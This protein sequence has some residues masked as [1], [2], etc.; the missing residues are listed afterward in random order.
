MLCSSFDVSRVVRNEGLTTAP[1]KYFRVPNFFHEVDGI[2]SSDGCMG[3]TSYPI[4]PI[5]C[6]SYDVSKIISGLT[7]TSTECFHGHTKF[8]H[9]LASVVGT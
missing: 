2:Y 1:I 7:T 3:P 5:L 6:S 8:L 9:E 4:G